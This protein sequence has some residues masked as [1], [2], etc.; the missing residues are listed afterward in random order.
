MHAVLHDLRYAARLLRRAPG[1]AAVVIATLT[2]GIGAV[3]A[4]FTVVNAVLLRPLPFH[5]PER[6]VQVWSGSGAR[7]HGPTSPANFLDWR[8]AT[9][10]FDAV[11]AEDFR[12]VNLPAGAMDGAPPQR[13]YAG[14]VSPAFFRAVGVGPV[15]G[16]GFAP[17]EERTDARVAV[18]GHAVWVG[19]FGGDRGVVGRTITLDGEAYQIV[20]V[21]PRG[22]DFP[23]PL[24]G[25]PVEL[26]LPLAWAPGQADRGIRRLGITARL[27]PGVSLAQAQREVDAVA[28]RLAA[29]YPRVNADVRIRLVPLREE[30]VGSSERP[31]LVLLGAVGLVLLIACANVA[32][33]LL[34]RAHARDREVALRAALGARRRRI[35]RQ[36]LAESVVLALA[37]GALGTLAA[38]W[39]TKALVVLAADA[40][41]RAAE[42]S[43][44]GR[45][46][47]FAL[48]T[49][50]VTGLLFGA[51]PALRLSGGSA[52][53][54][55][56]QGRTLTAGPRWQRLRGAL[57]VAEVAMAL[58]LLVGAG[59]LVRSLDRLLRVDP[60]FDPTHVLAARVDLP[61]PAYAAP[62]RQT[63]FV[64]DA[65]DRLAAAD[66]ATAAAI[67]Y[68]PFSGGDAYLDVT[69]DG[70]PAAT[71]A[72]QPAA[73]YRAVGG[74]YFA[75]M[76][77]PVLAGRALGA[78][79]RAGAPP[80]AVVNAAFVR[81]YWRGVDPPSVL[82]R[83]V[84]AGSSA[85]DGPWLTVV[86][87]VADVKHWG[88]DDHA[89]PELYRP[90]LQ[91]PS[92]HVTFVLRG[93][94][95]ATQAASMK[96]ALR[97]VDPDQPVTIAPLS[98]LVSAS[99]IA[100]RFRSALLGAFAA[101]ALVLALGGIYGVISYGVARRTREIGVRIALG[102]QRVEVVG[103]VLREGMRLTAL[104]LALGVV[105]A[106]W[107]TRLL[108]GMLFEVTPT[109]AAT[110]AGVSVLLAAAA[111][112][113]NYV[114]A[115]RASR[116]DPLAAIRSE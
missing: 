16:R 56:R 9:S 68:L 75:A 42:V 112:A 1:F 36:L 10:A 93:P 12:W 33:L 76:R 46:L 24:V 40:L 96:R 109:D 70:R 115:R 86:G 55:L 107:L 80:V 111:L 64:I 44:D 73:H 32:N 89:S 19:R 28:A 41:P 14:L 26:W 102:A 57:V 30:L 101:V 103:L 95:A 5:E 27:R 91:A 17:D 71:P 98:S 72:E 81:A 114:P 3:T 8:A 21:M 53:A 43:V 85:S 77:I 11:A 108:R 31:L 113:A 7:A 37:G 97:A 104:G 63:R 18:L 15:V 6:V 60:G 99:T 34:A 65:L 88:L 110:F 105:S 20:G 69:I 83:R 38:T 51:A 35:V 74:D 47:L 29:L 58:V 39:L 23:G 22:F 100:Q 78:A 49:A 79:D 52:D 2:V 61:E 25:T 116:V 50:V 84:R 82:G 66:G 90:L 48:A 94:D 45:A 62:E 13:L 4:I 92:A 106:L 59:L 67:D 54:A 87:V